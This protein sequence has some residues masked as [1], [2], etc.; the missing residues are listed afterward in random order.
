[1]LL[2]IKRSFKTLQKSILVIHWLSPQMVFMWSDITAN[3][4][5]VVRYYHKSLMS[6]LLC[7]VIKN[8]FKSLQKSM[9]AIH[10]LSPQ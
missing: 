3:G 8:S 7:I 4:V 2:L 1:M 5:Y 6:I 9:L 10:W